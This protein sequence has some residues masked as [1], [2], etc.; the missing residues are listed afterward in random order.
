MIVLD[1]NVISEPNK[2]LPAQQVLDWLNYQ[3]APALFTTT[4]NLA[5]LRFGIE[6]LT[7]GK[8]KT[9]LWAALEFTLGRLCAN[10]ILSFDLPS[11]EEL[12]RINA[13]CEAIGK[14]IG[15]AD[16][17]IAA[18]AKVNGFAVATRDTTPFELAGV[19][20]IDPWQQEL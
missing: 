11:A 18:V 9:A 20:V 5:E 19:T 13:R 3:Q 1:T 7:D 12:A 17:Q 15:L 8:K 16:A 2:R 14:K 4:I 6:R 10:R